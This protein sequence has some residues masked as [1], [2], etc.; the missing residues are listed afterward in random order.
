MPACGRATSDSLLSLS[1]TGSPAATPRGR[2]GLRRSL[3]SSSAKR[4]SVSS[5]SHAGRRTWALLQRAND[6]GCGSY[7]GT[8]AEDEP[9]TGSGAN[10]ERAGSEQPQYLAESASGGAHQ[11]RL[12]L[13]CRPLS[14]VRV[15][16][17]LD[18]RHQ[19]LDPLRVHVQGWDGLPHC[20]GELR[21]ALGVEA[22]EAGR[23]L[24]VVSDRC[25]HAVAGAVDVE[26]LA[27]G[28]C[29]VLAD[30]GSDFAPF[31]DALLT[32]VG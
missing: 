15:V 29:G 21:S 6:A 19:G 9:R 2:D 27:P 26:D 22:R 3:R 8:S 28:R 23:D 12:K 5:G 13:C 30:E 31:V 4:G 25:G 11:H 10:A 32:Q 18:V 7:Y 16:S 20:V 14:P 24:V 17:L 1:N